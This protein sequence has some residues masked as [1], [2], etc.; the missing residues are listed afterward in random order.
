MVQI[1]FTVDP[2]AAG[3][4]ET[5]AAQPVADAKEWIANIITNKAHLPLTPYDLKTLYLFAYLF[6]SLFMLCCVCCGIWRSC[7]RSRLQK[8]LKEE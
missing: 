7:K 3:S 4:A 6:L 5:I 1:D 2:Q 8:R